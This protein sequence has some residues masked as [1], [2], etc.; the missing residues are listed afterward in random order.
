MILGAI[1]VGV[2]GYAALGSIYFG[3]GLALDIIPL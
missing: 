3:A 1:A 2:L